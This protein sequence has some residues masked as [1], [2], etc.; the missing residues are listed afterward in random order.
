MEGH[1]ILYL[2]K[3]IKILK[4]KKETLFKLASFSFTNR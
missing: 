3:S 4:Q 1:Y 2:L